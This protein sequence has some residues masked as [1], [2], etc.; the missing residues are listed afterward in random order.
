MT[1]R[2]RTIV[3]TVATASIVTAANASQGAYFSQS[4]GWVALAFLIPTSLVLIL[5]RATTP[6]R[7]RTAF[8]ALMCALA[9]WIAL[10]SLWSVSQPAS[11]RETERML[12]YVGLA[13]ALAIVLRRGDAPGVT[14]G[15]FV[16][17]TL[18]SGYALATR[19][20]PDRFD[21][22]DDPSLPYR[23]SEPLGYWNAL[24]LLSAMGL[25][26]AIGFVAHGRRAHYSMVAGIVLPVLGATLYFTFSRGAWVGLAVGFGGMV[27]LDPRRLRLLWSVLIVAP[28]SVAC[29][30]YASRQDALTTE[31][32]PTAQAATEGHRFAVVVI[33]LTLC[34]GLLAV[35]ASLV[36]RHV[37]VSRG[38]VRAVNVG[39]A[40]SALAAAC[41][42]LVAAGGPS[43]GFSELKERFEADPVTGVDL[44]TRLFSV[45][46]NGRSES[47]GV[48]WEAAQER[49]VVGHGSGSY[50]FLWYERR[51]IELVIR[52][53]H[54]LY[55]ETLTELGAVGLALLIAALAVPLVGAFAARRSRFVAAGAGAFLAWLAASALDWHW[56]MVGVTLS[57]FL[58]GGAALLASDRR[59]P[60]PFSGARHW[61]AL[62]LSISLTAVSIVSLVGNQA[63][64]A[65]RDDVA[66]KNW[67]SATD[68]GRRARGLLFW[69]HEPELVLGDAAA[70]LGD[71]ASALS[72]Y[73]DAVRS[74]PANWVA[75]L[76]LAQVA[77]GDERAAAYEMV[78]RL[79]PLEENLPGESS[80]PSG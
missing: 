20:F 6:G 2:V 77:R 52:D 25:L 11:I 41:I 57:A 27:A 72:V 66:R 39:L 65:A 51:Q 44:N 76:R 42:A 15:V 71:R 75:W 79:N 8:A 58:L 67:A 47:I 31:D 13:L 53:A 14:G 38:F 50:E 36:A 12:V 7:L 1:R 17:I 23:L 4:W 69:S 29:I 21:T 54:S 78:R 40:A 24:G 26:V 61:V 64:F 3:V 32:V 19:L 33:A 56:E 70:G 16:G 68:H 22:Y 48:A 18:I 45:S 73:R 46:G 34:S 55:A 10:S 37:T 28:A 80:S 43:R 60:A 63:L 5:E 35:S 9:A 49:A 59:H 30:V 62:G 74:D